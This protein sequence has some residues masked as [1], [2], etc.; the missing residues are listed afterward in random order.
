MWWKR[1][2]SQRP[3]DMEIAEEIHAHLRMAI[4]DRIGRGE[5]PQEARRSALQELGN[6]G[7]AQEDTRAV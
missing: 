3:K 4:Q 1:L 7:L 5:S 2:F 6:A